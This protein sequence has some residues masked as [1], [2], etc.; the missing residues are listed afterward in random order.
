L[1]I[2]PN[3]L[4]LAIALLALS[5][6]SISQPVITSFTPV[7]GPI[8]TTVTING[9][10]FSASAAGNLV[11]FGGIKA[12]V[13]TAS[14]NTLTV[15]VPGGTT[16]R[17]LSVTTGGLTSW[18]TGAFDLTFP[19]GGSPLTPTSFVPGGGV[20]SNAGSLYS[21]VADFNGDG[22]MDLFSVE[23]FVQGLQ[24]YINSTVG[25]TI[26]FGQTLALNT[27]G[28]YHLGA[29]AGDLD[30]DGKP[31]IIIANDAQVYSLSVY[32]NTSAG[33]VVSFAANQDFPANND[34]G[35]IA[36]GDL[37]GDG[38]PDLVVADG[39]GG[40]ISFFRNTSTIGNISFAARVDINPGSVPASISIADLDRDGKA[41]LVLATNTGLGTMR[42]LSTP[43]N[44]SFGPFAIWG[45][46]TR[47][48]SARAGD[49][50]GD[51]KPDL[52]A[53]DLS[54]NSIVVVRNN[55]TPG[56]IAFA[57]AL[58]VTCALNTN[59]VDIDDMDGDG[60]PDLVSSN[61]NYTNVSVFRNTGTGGTL[62]FDAAADY[63]I[64]NVSLA[65]SAVAD[66][67]ANGR[68]DIIAGSSG[69]LVYTN[70]VGAAPP[71]ITSYT[72]TAGVTG[73]NIT[74]TGTHF[75]TTTNVSFGGTPA[76]SFT[77][78]SDNSITAIVGGGSSGPLTVD[79]ADA[80]ATALIGF[81]FYPPLI[82]DFYPAIGDK[83]SAITIYGSN[84]ANITDVKFGNS[85][86]ASFTVD[87]LGGITAIVGDGGTGD[88]TVTSPNGTTSLPGFSFSPP[89]ISSFAPLA[90]EVGS[91]VTITGRNFSPDTTYDIVRFGAVKASLVS[92][93]ATQ[94][95]VRVPAGASYQ[96]LSVTTNARTAFATKPFLVT[97]P[98][99]DPTITPHSFANAGN[100][101]TVPNPTDVIV[102]DLDGDGK[103]DMVVLGQ[104]GYFSLFLSSS[105]IGKIG[106]A[107]R[108]DYYSDADDPV[109]ILLQDMNGDGRPEIIVL[110][111]GAPIGSY[112]PNQVTVISNNL[113]PG[114]GFIGGH[115]TVYTATGT[116]GICVADM[117]GDGLPD[118]VVSNGS[119]GTISVYPNTTYYGGD[120]IS[121]GQ[122]I[123][124]P[125]I[126]HPGYIIAAD[127][128]QDGRPDLIAADASGNALTAYRNTS[129][130]GKF[131][132]ASGVNQATL[133][134]PTYITA[135][136][137]RGTGL[138]DLVSGQNATTA[139]IGDLNGDGKA[140]LGFGRTGSGLISLWQNNY[141]GTGPLAFT[142]T[143]DIAAGQG[144][145]W[146]YSSDLDGDS[147]PDLIVANPG[148][149]SVSIFRNTI[150]DPVITAVSPDTAYKG[151]LIRLTGRNFTGGTNTSFGSVSADSMH[152]VSSTEIDAVVGP[153]ASGNV[154]V[155]TLFGFGSI[156]GF[157]FIPQ[158]IAEG[159]TV[160]CWGNYV[161]LRSTADSNNQWFLNGAAIAGD[162]ALRA[163]SAGSYTVQ[164]TSNGITT[165]S[166]AQ[167]VIVKKIPPPVITEKGSDSLVSSALKG[168]QW[169]YDS[170]IVLDSTRTIRPGPAGTYSVTTTR[171]GCNSGPSILYYWG[172]AQAI[173][174]PDDQYIGFYPNPVTNYLSIDQHANG[175]PLLLDLSFTDAR[176]QILL[177]VRQTPGAL[178]D[179][180]SL[181]A[182]IIFMHVHAD[183]AYKVDK[184]VKI[185]KIK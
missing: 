64:G 117:N 149:N 68:P 13:L 66:M 31:D 120:I 9:S 33:G 54:G 22:K 115:A 108:T 178:V 3:R 85:S 157:V 142:P 121:F 153:G 109:R 16:Y 81:T 10:G 48:V 44:F 94:L 118:I 80:T 59:H 151:T 18:S 30:G 36:I 61:I 98:S 119:T 56:S 184:T 180:S 57:A 111:G 147:K 79:N 55:S 65:F 113:Y 132:L 40:V 82:R 139:A 110:N 1:T 11:D 124:Y 181:P 164:T 176:G 78:N 131:G 177:T 88:I 60:K 99:D 26:S 6:Y 105:S 167:T 122:A 45:T 7:N 162:T 172:G 182:G 8:G 43:G 112:S 39:P 146:Y 84:F 152:V 143:V 104:G 70:Q 130:G 128:D 171:E 95:Q 144:D 137:L 63:N 51:G 20:Y 74:I 92:A 106:F 69:F 154:T 133:T 5:L 150:G 100:F 163:D 21:G 86:A 175:Q 15:T 159:D 134:N 29:A 179:V 96:P 52:V 19:G 97:F 129:M 83:G 102:G 173:Q 125:A 170:Y 166:P 93:S 141:P 77:I 156:G 62:T 41:D 145:T 58:G 87:S 160:F 174:L 76:S 28:T 148:Q 183:G 161:M 71:T 25:H 136:D 35:E 24:V 67:D 2:R 138:P 140:D 53:T 90:G 126:G 47:L 123:D 46:G 49:L 12:T 75:T 165:V 34:P 23:G 107:P 42:N 169:Y 37:D 155:T 14:A 101:P 185:L 38:K 17:P 4:I 32:R 103:P 168:N 127:L 91:I 73:T 114:G 72:P 158:I 135:G 50:D 89:V 27:P 116:Q